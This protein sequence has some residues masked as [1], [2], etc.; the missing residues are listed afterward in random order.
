MPT[1]LLEIA[2][3]EELSLDQELEALPA[4]R[5]LKAVRSLIALYMQDAPLKITARPQLSQQTH[6]RRGDS[7][8]S[9][10]VDATVEILTER[11]KRAQSLVIMKELEKRG[12]TFQGK[13]P[14]TGLAS[15]LSHSP[16]FD[17]VRGLG[18]GLVSWTRSTESHDG[19]DS[20]ADGIPEQKAA[21]P[22]LETAA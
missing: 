2:V 9:R 20:A 10:I 3:A 13:K 16:Q 1:S 14:T 21:D 4:Y 18:Y 6:S 11:G 17:N 22:E 8:S 15:T 12:F 5:K 7:L 19:V